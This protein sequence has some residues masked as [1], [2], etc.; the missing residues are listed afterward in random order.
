MTGNFFEYKFENLFEKSIVEKYFNIE[1]LNITR[2]TIYYSI[3]SIKELRK[4]KL[5][6]LN[7]DE[8]SGIIQ[9]ILD[10]STK[11]NISDLM[12]W[13]LSAEIAE[14]IDREIL[15]SLQSYI[16]ENSKI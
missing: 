1:Y 6:L 13:K 12:E 14:G 2:S 10:Y 5:L 4:I 16:D 15:K 8:I 11:A 9:K 7:Q 3:L